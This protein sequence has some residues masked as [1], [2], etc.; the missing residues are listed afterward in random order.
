[1]DS[2]MM[3]KV[4]C[5][6]DDFCEN[7]YQCL[8]QQWLVIPKKVQKSSLSISEVMTIII[9]FHHSG[10]RCF[11]YFYQMLLE[12]TVYRNIF[13]HLVSYNRFVEIMPQSLICFST[14]MSAKM[15]R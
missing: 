6:V 9:M 3:T 1:M 4:F 10:F 13:P 7:F 5:D 15:A 12:I 11:K 8:T 14:Y 2:N